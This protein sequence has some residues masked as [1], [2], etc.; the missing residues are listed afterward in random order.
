MRIAIVGGG[1]VGLATAW[2]LARDGHDVSIFDQGPIPNPAGASWDEHRLI[3]HHYPDR[4]L[5]ARMVGDAYRAWNALW[6]DLGEVHYFETGALGLSRSGGDWTGRAREAVEAEGLDHEILPPA[7]LAERYPFLTL[8]GVRW[9]LFMQRGGI[10]LA[11]RIIAGLADH[12]RQ[13][14][15]HLF[16]H[17]PVAEVDLERGALRLVSGVE[18]AADAIVL[19][20]G[21]WTPRLLPSERDRLRSHRVL[22]VYAEPPAEYAEAWASAPAMVDYGYPDDHWSAPPAAGTRLKL[23]VAGH[24]RPGDPDDGRDILPGEA[25][26]MLGLY[27]P[28]LKDVDR[29][30]VLEARTCCYTYAPEERFVVEKRGKGW[31]V[32]ACSGHGFKFGALMGQRVAAGITGAIAPDALAKWAAAR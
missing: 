4:P 8:D 31:L 14:G 28:V 23:A 13:R 2:S 17:T 29:Y 26:E 21:A 5:H 20:T 18:S 3:R 19:A 22:V 12:L 30:K 11:D 16:E 25:E 7:A 6:A 1:I 27:R 10:L 24:G 15:V 9:G 32:S